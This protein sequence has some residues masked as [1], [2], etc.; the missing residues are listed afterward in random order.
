MLTHD[1]AD[2]LTRIETGNA[3]DAPVHTGRD[4]SFRKVEYWES[5]PYPTKLWHWTEAEID[6]FLAKHRF[7]TRASALGM[8]N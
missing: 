7:P 8:N 6:A 4:L 1:L 2:V 5:R 3:C